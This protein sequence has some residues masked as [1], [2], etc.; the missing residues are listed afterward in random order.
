MAQRVKNLTSLHED[1]SL[2]P[3]LAQWAKDPE[4]PWPLHRLAVA[5]LI[6]P[7]ARELPHAAGVALKRKEKKEN[8]NNTANMK[9]MIK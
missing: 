5:A 6:P 4:L 9:G 3:D 8:S 2:I 1:A 7:L